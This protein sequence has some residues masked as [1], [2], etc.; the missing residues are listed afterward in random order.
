MS[1][2]KRQLISQAFNDVGLAS[3]VFDLTPEQ[4]QSAGM[5]LDMLIS[6]WNYAGIKFGYPVSLSGGGLDLDKDSNLPFYAIDTVVSNLA[7]LLCPAFGKVPSPEL[8]QRAKDGYNELIKRAAMPPEMQITG[9]PKGA[10]AKDYDRPFLD[11][12]DTS[13]IKNT[14][15]DQLVF[16]S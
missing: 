6:R 11:P 13:P 2:T 14:P 4:L 7:I 12:A 3:F 8:K 9:M 5:Q 1:W 15:N 10:G 16:G